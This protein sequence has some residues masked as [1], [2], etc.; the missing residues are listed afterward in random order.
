LPFQ[1]NKNRLLFSP[2]EQNPTLANRYKFDCHSR[3]S[4][5]IAVRAKSS[6][7]SIAILTAVLADCRSLTAVLAV[8]AK[9]NTSKSIQIVVPAKSPFEQNQTVE[10]RYKFEPSRSN[11]KLVDCQSRHH[12]SKSIAVPIESKR[13]KFDCRS[14][15]SSEI[16]VRTKSNSR[17]SIQIR[18][19]SFKQ[20]IGGLSVSPSQ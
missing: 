4:S 5:E 16:A 20:K 11:R 12:R 9:S 18:A 14:C 15:R 3:R 6:S 2:F 19:F 13:Y 8:R 17:E 10:N 7:E 1:Q